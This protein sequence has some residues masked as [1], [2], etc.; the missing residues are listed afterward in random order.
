MSVSSSLDSLASLTAAP[1]PTIAC[2]LLFDRDL[3][4][5]CHIRVP[6]THHRLSA[7]YVDNHFYSFFKVIPDARKALDV[8]LR[9]GKRDN[10]AALTHTRRGYAIWA[11]ETGAH[12]A[13]PARKP[14]FGPE[15]C[16]MVSDRNTY[17]PCRLQVPDVTQ[18]LNG[19]AYNNRF[20]SIFK[21]ETD[22]AKVLDVAAKLA[23][24]GDE[25]LLIIDPP[26]FTLALVEPTARLM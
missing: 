10:A 19:L 5:P 26:A 12:Y 2:K 11:H 3:Y 22:A 17:Q 9:L 20:Y 6:D 13:P 14:V 25:T 1:A 21:Q 8:L 7:I 4:T 24:R 16:M 23:R 18:P 15:A